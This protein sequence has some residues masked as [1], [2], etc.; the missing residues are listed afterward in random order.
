MTYLGTVGLVIDALCEQGA[1]PVVT[2]P[3]LD[4]V[5]EC[6]AKSE[7]DPDLIASRIIARRAGNAAAGQTTGQAA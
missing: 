5:A 2:D 7:R 1:G 4:F 6:Y 3:E